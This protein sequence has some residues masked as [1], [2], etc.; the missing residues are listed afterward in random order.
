MTQLANRLLGL[1]VSDV[2]AGACIASSPCTKC[3]FWVQYFT[4][5]KGLCSVKKACKWV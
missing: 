5:C 1:F 2:K 3:S 4:N